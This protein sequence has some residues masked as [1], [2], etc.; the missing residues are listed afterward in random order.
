MRWVTK[1]QP[2]SLWIDILKNAKTYEE[3][4]EAAFQLDVLLGNDLWYVIQTL[5]S[6]LN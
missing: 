5:F 2:T 4:E 3:W 6:Y 1:K